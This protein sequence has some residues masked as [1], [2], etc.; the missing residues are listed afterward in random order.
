[1]YGTG[2]E[3]SNYS[4]FS[5]N[6]AQLSGSHTWLFGSPLLSCHAGAY[7]QSAIEHVAPFLC[8][9]LIADAILLK[10]S[11]W[12]EKRQSKKNCSPCLSVVRSVSVGGEYNSPA[13]LRTVANAAQS[14]HSL[15]CVTREHHKVRLTIIVGHTW[16][17]RF[18]SFSSHV[19][20]N[21]L[22]YFSFSLDSDVERRMSLPLSPPPPL[23]CSS[24]RTSNTQVFY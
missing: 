21:L 16:Q 18:S 1:M 3:H 10:S 9:L 14:F 20:G 17:S 15:L 19:S 24:V 11:C 6:C 12:V 4:M 5:A 23:Q 2:V 7:V 13:G 22:F 8:L